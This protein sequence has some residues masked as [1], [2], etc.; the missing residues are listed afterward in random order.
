MISQKVV[1]DISR[2]IKRVPVRAFQTDF[3]FSN[4]LLGNKADRI[5]IKVSLLLSG[6][7]LN[8]GITKFSTNKVTGVK[9]FE[10]FKLFVYPS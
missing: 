10:T 2:S 7:T 8:V 6:T 3:F 4:R 9:L 5:I 1:F